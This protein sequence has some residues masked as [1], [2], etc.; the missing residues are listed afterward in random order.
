MATDNND[1]DSLLPS[2]PPTSSEQDWIP[3]KWIE[4]GMDTLNILL[5]V[6]C[7]NSYYLYPIAIIFWL[8]AIWPYCTVNGVQYE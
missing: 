5:I 3:K 2:S 6:V 8:C 1:K 7:Y 4:K